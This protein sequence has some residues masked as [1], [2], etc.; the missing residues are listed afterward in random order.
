MFKEFENWFVLEEQFMKNK[1][2]SVELFKPAKTENTGIYADIFN[3]KIYARATLW[4]SN[5]FQL[6]AINSISEEIVIFEYHR[7]ENDQQLKL[8]LQGFIN[9]IIEFK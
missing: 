9:R 1:A 3:E 5:E 8:L 6:E 4:E 7:L 2:L